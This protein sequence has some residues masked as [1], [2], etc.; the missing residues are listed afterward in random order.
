MVALNKTPLRLAEYD[1]SQQKMLSKAAGLKSEARN[2]NC[3]R[4]RLDLMNMKRL[5]YVHFHHHSPLGL[6]IS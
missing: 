1:D 3:I 4:M 2:I 5:Q 6:V